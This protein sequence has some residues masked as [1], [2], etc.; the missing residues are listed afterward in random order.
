[1][2]V[3]DAL[4]GIRRLYVE[5][6]PLIYYVEE[7]PAHVTKMDAIIAAVDSAS[8]EAV[9]SV[10]TLTEVLVHPLKLGDSH[11]GQEYRDIL[12][13]GSGFRLQAVTASIA[14]AAAGLRARYDLRTPD[15]LHVATAVE[16][17]CDAFLTNDADMKR[18]NEL[19]VLILDELES[20]LLGASS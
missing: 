3:S 7:N 8:I 5:T 11:L 18:V 13:H 19:K 6:A 9:S 14:E 17:G 20:D 15:A 10:I 1:V 2:K 12:L 4:R 16:A